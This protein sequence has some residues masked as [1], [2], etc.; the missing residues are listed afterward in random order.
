MG[1]KQKERRG[2]P[3]IDLASEDETFKAAME[4][5][6]AV[7]DKDLES[8][9][10]PPATVKRASSRKGKRGQG[11]VLESL[12]LHGKNTERALR[13]LDSFVQRARAAGRRRVLVITGKGLRSEGGAPVLKK[14]VG[15]WLRGS[16]AG[17]VERVETAP[18]HLGGEGALIVFLRPRARS[19]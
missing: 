17:R 4:A 8:A 12:D 2:A 6:G 1:R 5:L 18:R 14:A 16:G 15:R 7:P 3:P 10:K 19:R 13:D 9:K 11:D